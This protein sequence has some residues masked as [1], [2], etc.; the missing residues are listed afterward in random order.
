[1]KE[2]ERDEEDKK[3]HKKREGGE[4][5]KKKEQLKQIFQAVNKGQKTYYPLAKC[6]YYKYFH[7]IQ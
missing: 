5:R 4:K 6:W 7:V 2:I 1:M 3:Q